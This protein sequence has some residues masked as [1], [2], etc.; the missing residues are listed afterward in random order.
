[1]SFKETKKRVYEI[2]TT[3]GYFRF[4]AEDKQMAKDHLWNLSH[5]DPNFIVSSK[6]EF[7]G[8]ATESDNLDEMFLHDLCENI[9]VI[10]K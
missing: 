6:V 8:W 3:N 10:S 9:I 7:I 5:T 4:F 1:M 2:E